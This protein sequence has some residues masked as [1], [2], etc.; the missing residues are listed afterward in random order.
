MTRAYFAVR[1]DG[2]G[3]N[4]HACAIGYLTNGLDWCLSTVRCPLAITVEIGIA[5]LSR[6]KNYSLV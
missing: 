4:F 2:A 1:R 6:P 3:R 5:E